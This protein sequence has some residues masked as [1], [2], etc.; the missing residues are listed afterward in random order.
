MFRVK[1]ADP[2]S[3]HST[4][5]IPFS[6]ISANSFAIIS[7]CGNL[8]FNNDRRP[9]SQIYRPT[10]TE[11]APGSSPS[12]NEYHIY[13]RSPQHDDNQ[14]PAGRS[15]PWSQGQGSPLPDPHPHRFP[16]HSRGRNHPP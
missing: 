1:A 11:T 3:G 15:P 5:K 14:L 7:L 6:P 2:F 4:T 13:G 8:L 12:D 9:T 10:W 16:T